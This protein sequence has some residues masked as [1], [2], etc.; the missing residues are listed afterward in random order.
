M[1]GFC[2]KLETTVISEADCYKCK[3]V[4]LT[5]CRYWRESE[6]LEQDT[7]D[8]VIVDAR[9]NLIKEGYICKKCHTLF[10]AGDH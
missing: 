4:D 1:I 2:K 7:C 5:C 3:N 8:H 10:K 6:E 9:N